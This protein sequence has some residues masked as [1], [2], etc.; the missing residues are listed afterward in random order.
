MAFSSLKESI[1]L[2]MRITSPLNSWILAL[3]IHSHLHTLTHAPSPEQ[4]EEVRLVLHLSGRSPSPSLHTSQ[5]LLSHWTVSNSYLRPKGCIRA[6]LLTHT[7]HPHYSHSPPTLC[8]RLA[9]DPGRPVLGAYKY[10][11]TLH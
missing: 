11:I 3:Y 6:S 9:L 10:H 4:T 1:S 8:C 7:H 5:S 2:V